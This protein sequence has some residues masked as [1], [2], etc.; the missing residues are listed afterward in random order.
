MRYVDKNH[1]P[2]AIR[3]L[4]ANI[5]DELQAL[6][7]WVLWRYVWKEDRGKGE[8]AKIPMQATG[9]P[10]RSNDPETW[11]TFKA[12]LSAWEQ[13][14]A[15]FDGLGFMFTPESGIVGVD[16][17]N[18]V[19]RDEDGELR[20]SKVAARVIELLDSYTELSPSGTGVH[21]IVKASIA[22][23]LK[24]AKTGIEIYNKGRYFTVTGALWADFLPVAERSGE[25]GRIIGGIKDAKEKAKTPAQT[26]NAPALTLTVDE[27]LR[28][29]MASQNADSISRL[30]RGDTSDYSGDAS[31]AD[32][33]LASKLA[34]WSEGRADVLDAMFRQ[35]ALLRKKWDER[36]S[37][38]GRTY[39]EMTISKALA[40]CTEF[41]D[42]Q[43]RP[44][45]TLTT[46]EQGQQALEQAY[47]ERKARRFSMAELYER[48][49][50]YRK[51]PSVQGA[52]PGWEN[53]NEFYRPRKGLFSVVT[54]IPSHGKSSW[55]NALC[56]NLTHTVG[57]KFLFCSFETQPIEQHV[58]DIARIILGKPTFA[59]AEGA[60]T[61]QE[62]YD[63]CTSYGEYFQFA[64]VAEDDMNVDG[65]LSYAADAVRDHQIDGFIFDPWSELN[66]PSK[67]VGNYTQFVQQGLNKIRRFTREN[68]I[69]T[70]L[71]AHPTKFLAKGQKRDVPTL[72]DVA[73]SAHFYNKADY[74]IVVYRPDDTSSLSHVHVQKVRFYATGKK[75]ACA[76][77]Y[78]PRTGRFEE[79]HYSDRRTVDEYSF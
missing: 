5:P 26:I 48:A 76:F 68:N 71:V 34:F 13:A 40:G 79:T 42:A 29:A 78:D 1:R 46:K 12:A 75:G 31:A 53:L 61:D 19:E 2:A 30:F 21:V 47:A 20:L 63:A 38:D 49:N 44:Q 50:A 4:V 54:G 45:P 52:H 58:C 39:G 66:P 15:S 67:L 3:P 60:A 56:Y 70:W 6:R 32:L 17:D 11:V 72:Y 14:K 59:G 64:Q 62:F 65:V 7:Q 69:H 28:K 37:G 27:R 22:E 55:L 77:V 24:D 73:D 25:L 41:Y 36:H 33:A 43:R 16:V 35:S 51:E 9:T 10:A 8:W 23:A 18:C 57:W 74:G